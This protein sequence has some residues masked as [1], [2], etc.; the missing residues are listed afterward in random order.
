MGNPLHF[1][2]EGPRRAHQLLRD[3]YEQLGD[4][5]GTRLS[6]KAMFL[7]SVSM[8]IMILPIE[9]ILKYRRNPAHVHMN[10]R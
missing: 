6:L 7:L 9:R 8:P 2:L 4:S 10:D 3:L 1:R 5:D